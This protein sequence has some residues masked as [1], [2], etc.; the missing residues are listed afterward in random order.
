LA[1]RPYGGHIKN[2][3]SKRG[4]SAK[5]GGCVAYLREFQ[6]SCHLTSDGVKGH[7][8]QVFDMRWPLLGNVC[9]DDTPCS[10]AFAPEK[11]MLRWNPHITRAKAKER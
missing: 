3:T 6:H 11:Q 10:F 8:D 2:S 5:S 7:V 1:C 4:A 9:R